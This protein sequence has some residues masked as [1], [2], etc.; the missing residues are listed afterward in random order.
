M[1][2]QRSSQRSLNLLTSEIKSNASSE[3]SSPYE[4]F[5][6][7]D[8]RIIGKI[9]DSRRMCARV[10]SLEIKTTVKNTIVF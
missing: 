10:V 9:K 4:S 8:G 2:S 3:S 5:V 1:W 7:N 6:Q